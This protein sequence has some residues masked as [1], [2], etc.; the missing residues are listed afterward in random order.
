MNLDLAPLGHCVACQNYD[1][2]GGHA[3]LMVR[4]LSLIRVRKTGKT[5]NHLSLFNNLED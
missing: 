3:P 5:T 1:R 4:N 2:V